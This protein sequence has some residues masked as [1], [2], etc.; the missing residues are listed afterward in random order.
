MAVNPKSLKNLKSTKKGEVLNP[1]GRGKGVP[2]SS[3]RLLKVLELIQ[4]KQ[5]KV[6]GIVEDMSVAEQMDLAQI[7]KAIEGDL[8][9]YREIMDRLEG[10]SKQSMDLTTKGESLNDTGIENLTNDEKLA[11][12]RLKQKMNSVA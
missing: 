10:K 3:T 12:I 4:E 8:L 6:T 5:N 7:A 1:K 9:S 2:N 11:L